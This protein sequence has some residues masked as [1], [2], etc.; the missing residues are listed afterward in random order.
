MEILKTNGYIGST[1][2]YEFIALDKCGKEVK[3]L[4]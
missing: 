1:M 2:G 3:W 4:R